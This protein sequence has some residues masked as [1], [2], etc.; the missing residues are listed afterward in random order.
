[1]SKVHK[2]IYEIHVADGRGNRKAER[3]FVHPLSY[4]LATFGYVLTV[5]SFDKYDLYGLTGMALYL[6]IT[7]IW[8]GISIKDALSRLWPVLL[9]VGMIG[10]ANPFLDKAVY[11][12][13]GSFL[14]TKGMISMAT[15]ML[16][17]I[18][19]VMASYFLM[20]KT[21]M[22]GVCHSLRCLHVPKEFVTILLLM[23]RYSMVLLKEVE[24]MM[25]AYKLRAPQQKGLHFKIW[26]DFVG[27]LL[28]RSIDRAQIVYESMLLRGYHGEFMGKRLVWKKGSSACYVLIWLMVFICFRIVPVFEIV[29]RL[30]QM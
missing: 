2:A 1:M 21:G 18:F 27:Q 9:L 12:Q 19:C 8:N 29:G 24:R 6:L 26:G 30:L 17:G 22:E 23:Y 5:I 16:K 25:Q 11:L 4:V 14:V 20:A 10:I 28:L 15:L 3:A 13:A 7:G